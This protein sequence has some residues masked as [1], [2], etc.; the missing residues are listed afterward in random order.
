MHLNHVTVPKQVVDADPLAVE[1]AL[2]PNARE[3][4]SI[5][6]IVMYGIGKIA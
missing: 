4:E 6:K 2:A 5:P 1:F 3:L